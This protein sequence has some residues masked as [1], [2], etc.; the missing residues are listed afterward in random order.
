MAAE[1][2]QVLDDG[3]DGARQ[4]SRP[5]RGGTLFVI[6]VFACGLLL[7]LA[8]L[9]QLDQGK[10]LARVVLLVMLAGVLANLAYWL[11]VYKRWNH[12]IEVDESGISYVTQSA[13]STLLWNEIAEIRPHQLL[14]DAFLNISG[15]SGGTG[16]RVYYALKGF[17][18]LALEIAAHTQR[19]TRLEALHVDFGPEN[20]HRPVFLISLSAVVFVVAGLVAGMGDHVVVRGVCLGAAAASAFVVVFRA[21]FSITRTVISQE[22]I[23]VEKALRRQSWDLCD[24]EDVLIGLTPGQLKNIEVR[25]QLVGGRR[26][27]VLAQGVNPVLLFNSLRTATES[28]GAGLS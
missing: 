8:L 16:I 12:C 2:S 5:G 6:A 1:E 19:R 17:E 9:G 14:P 22:G 18:E 15:V 3:S 26:I 10:A 13:R 11:L 28:A 4:F 25:I 20:P 23:A 21:L 7:L 27:S 24:V